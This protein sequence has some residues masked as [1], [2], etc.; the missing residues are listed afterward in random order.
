[1]L[2]IYLANVYAKSNTKFLNSLPL[3]SGLKLSLGLKLL[4]G[5]LAQ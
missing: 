4:L 2:Y 1:M 5:R 3:M